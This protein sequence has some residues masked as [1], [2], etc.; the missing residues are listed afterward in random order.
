MCVCETDRQCYSIPDWPWAQRSPFAQLWNFSKSEKLKP[1][2]L[3]LEGCLKMYDPF[4]RLYLSLVRLWFLPALQGV[5][6]WGFFFFKVVIERRLL[7]NQMFVWWHL[8]LVYAQCCDSYRKSLAYLTNF[9]ESPIFF[10]VPHCFITWET[11]NLEKLKNLIEWLSD[12][13]NNHCV[14]AGFPLNSFKEINP[15]FKGG[16]EYYWFCNSIT[17]WRVGT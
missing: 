2:L 11:R 13:H 10:V 6:L 4:S 8:S 5:L 7:T 3:V 16:V 1:G 17:C 15:V 12:G 9:T 14:L